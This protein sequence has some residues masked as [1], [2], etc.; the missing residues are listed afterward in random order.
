VCVVGVLYIV[1]GLK[2]AQRE[3]E[4]AAKAA[5]APKHQAAAPMI[6]TMMMIDVGT[7]NC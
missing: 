4:R 1:C 5:A 7:M 6:Q 3:R 2:G